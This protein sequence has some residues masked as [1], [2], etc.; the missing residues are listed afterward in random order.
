MHQMQQTQWHT[1]PLVNLSLWMKMEI[2][3][4]V[5]Q[6]LPTQTIQ[7]MRLRWLP[8]TRRFQAFLA[9]LLRLYLPHQVTCLAILRLFTLRTI[10][11]QVL[12]TVMK[13]AVQSLKQLLWLVSLA[14]RLTTQQ[15]NVSNT[16]KTLAMPLWQMV[17]QLVQALTWI[18]QLTKLGQ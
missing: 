9:T 14:K 3:F 15:L 11:K 8:S 12:L 18:A 2:Q 13:Q 5:Y 10:K 7:M 16:I 17:T 1:K 6:Q 4:Q